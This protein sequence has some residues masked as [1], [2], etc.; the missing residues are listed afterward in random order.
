[1]YTLPMHT[2]SMEGMQEF[3]ATLLLHLTLHCTVVVVVAQALQHLPLVCPVGPQAA[4][5][6]IYRHICL[7]PHS[8]ASCALEL[9][10]FLAVLAQHF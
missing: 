2:Y 7:W 9:H 4:D 3:E 10:G 6:P 5:D 1:M 8:P